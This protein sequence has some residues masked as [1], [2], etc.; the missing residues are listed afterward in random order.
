MHTYVLLHF[1][2]LAGKVGAFDDELRVQVVEDDARARLRRQLP[3]NIFVQ[4]LAGP[5]EVR[6]GVMGF[7]LRLV[8]QISLVA[9]PLALLIFFQL[10]FLPYHNEVITWWQRCTIIADLALL[11]MLWPSVARGETTRLGWRDLQRGRVVAAATA[12]LAA[13]LLVLCVATFPG[14]WLDGNLPSARFLPAHWFIATSQTARPEWTSLH[15]VL[16]A[17]E[18]DYVARKPRSLWSNRLV[19]PKIEVIDHARFD[20]EAK[21]AALTETLSLRGRRLEGA[22]LLFAG[23]TKADFTAAQ[24]GGAKLSGADLTQAKFECDDTGSEQQCAD[25]RGASLEGARL[26]E[27]SLKGASLAGV[28]LQGTNLERAKLRGA[29]LYRARLQGAWLKDAQ[30]QGATLDEADLRGASLNGAQLQGAT[31]AETQLDS[32]SLSHSFVWR[33]EVRR[34]QSVEGV[35][36]VAPEAGRKYRLLDCPIEQKDPCE[37]S[38]DSFLALKRLIEQH[39]PDGER[40]DAAL[41]QIAT[42]DP[43]KPLDGGWEKHWAALERSSPALDIYERSLAISWQEIGCNASGAPHVIHGLLRH[44]D[45]RFPPGNPQPADLAAAFL[46]E[47]HCLGARGLRRG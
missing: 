32:A 38:I 1:A 12:S 35:F 33:A 34:A 45:Q 42:L 44:F 2:L 26:E 24:L 4:F 18:V 36:V 31:F 27:A 22:V 5:R 10:Q 30:L 19:L 39:L 17:G 47:A 7:L 23:L 25:L 20:T 8:A 41:E 43:V 13:V 11:W 14:E 15:E 40:R 9:G 21:I 16:V 46:D 28:E 37:W 6:T 3:S 29:S